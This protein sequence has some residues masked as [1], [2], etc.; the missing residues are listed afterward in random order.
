MDINQLPD[1]D[2]IRGA[3]LDRRA[4]LRDSRIELEYLDQTGTVV[5]LSMPFLDGM[6]LL[7]LLRGLQAETGFQ[8]P[9]DPYQSP[10]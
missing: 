9:D 6:Y 5:K 8:M 10:S 2:R 3:V 7:N 4:T 1:V